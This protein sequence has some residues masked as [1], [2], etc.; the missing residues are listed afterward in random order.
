MHG[1]VTAWLIGSFLAV[2]VG[3][4]A[5]AQPPAE[6]G[7]QGAGK[8]AADMMAKCKDMMADRDKMMADM[9]TADA[10]LNELVSKMNAASGQAKV[11]ATAAVVTELVEQRSAMRERMM[12]MQQGTMGHMMEH[13]QAGP[14]SMA[15]CP[16]M[17][18]EGMKHE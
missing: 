12:R 13:A 5:Q 3:L 11:D 15:A 9:K 10:R 16:M 4:G 17:K 2:A 7:Q 14:Q 6:Q 18:M 8:P 1:R